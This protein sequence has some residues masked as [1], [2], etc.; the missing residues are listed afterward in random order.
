MKKFTRN[1]SSGKAAAKEEWMINHGDN[2]EWAAWRPAFIKL[3]K[4]RLLSAPDM[5]LFERAGKRCALTEAGGNCP[6]GQK[7]N[8]VLC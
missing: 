5:L 8:S 2:S 1:P 4:N 6:H 3:P 7:N